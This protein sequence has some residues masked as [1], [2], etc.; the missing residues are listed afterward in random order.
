MK[1]VYIKKEVSLKKIAAKYRPILKD[2]KSELLKYSDKIHSIYLYGSVATGQAKS[3]T[4]DLDIVVVLKLK[5]TTRLK[6]QLKQLE[7]S[8]SQKYQRTFREVGFAVT[9]KNEVLRGKESYGWRF[10]LT[11]L[12]V[13][14]F[15]ETLYQKAIKFSPTK[16][17][18][19]N[20][21]SDIDKNIKEARRKIK[22]ADE[23]D[24]NLHIKSI[25]K[26]II[27]T[28]FSIVMEKEN[29]WTTGLNEMTNIFVKHYPE[30]KKEIN[31]VLKI[32][33][34]KSPDRKSAISILD[35]FGKW[36]SSEFFKQV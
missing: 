19:R 24:A 34:S 2:V 17:L 21:H 15:G 16:K 11:I 18:A 12:S 1:S 31:A 23:D 35:T 4:S 26:K 3:P 8:L 22:S 5:P 6:D 32:A 20:L 27:R 7:K 25:M 10:F 14:I 13:K 28:A 36:V 29:Y 30:K 33:K 9:H